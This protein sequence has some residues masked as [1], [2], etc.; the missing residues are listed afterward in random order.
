MDWSLIL[1]LYPVLVGFMWSA[2][3]K[4]KEQVEHP[5]DQ[6]FL[7]LSKVYTCWNIHIGGKHTTSFV[8]KLT[9]PVWIRCTQT[10][11][12][13]SDHSGMAKL[14]IT[15]SCWHEWKW[16]EAHA[17]QGQ[18]DADCQEAF[19]RLLQIAFINTEQPN[20]T[21]DLLQTYFL[22]PLLHPDL[23]FFCLTSTFAEIL[24]IILPCHSEL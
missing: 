13:A 10:T 11:S 18:F 5:W 21:I 7:S 12:S 6:N 16:P 19:Q 3:R 20:F 1:F 24:V 22:N 17:A 23:S 2:H 9:L 8:P 14:W 15:L 4:Y